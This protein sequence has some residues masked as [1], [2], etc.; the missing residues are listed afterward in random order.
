[1][2]S[3]AGAVTA[4]AEVVKPGWAESVHPEELAALVDTRVCFF[5]VQ[6]GGG[7]EVCERSSFDGRWTGGGRARGR[8][9]AAPIVSTAPLD[10]PIFLLGRILDVVDFGG[11]VGSVADPCASVAQAVNEFRSLVGPDETPSAW[12]AKP[13]TLRARFASGAEA[14]NADGGSGSA[15]GASAT[16]AAA[17]GA[18]AGAGTGAGAGML[19]CVQW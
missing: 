8:A 9:C 17:A 15:R 3:V 4:T 13:D 1:V 12:S 14:D 2:L 6:K 7:A 16:P 18:A 10:P 5:A 19:Q 11:P